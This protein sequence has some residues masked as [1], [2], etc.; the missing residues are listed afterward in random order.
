MRFLLA[1]TLLLLCLSSS[2]AEDV[3]SVV[4]LLEFVIDVDEETAAKC[5]ATLRERVQSGEVTGEQRDAIRSQLGAKLREVLALGRESPLYLDTLMLATS[6]GEPQAA[7]RGARI[8]RKQS[9]RC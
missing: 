9:R 7:K 5:L 6:W 2:V 4:A 3:E 1:L 8:G